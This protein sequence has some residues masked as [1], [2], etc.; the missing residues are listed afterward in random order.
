VLSR[1]LVKRDGARSMG[2]EDIVEEPIEPRLANAAAYANL[3]KEIA[4]SVRS[5]GFQTNALHYSTISLYND[6][7]I[8]ED[9]LINSRLVRY[10]RQSQVSITS[11]FSDPAITMLSMLGRE[12]PGLPLQS[13][14]E[15]VR[16]DLEVGEAIAR[17]RSIRT[18]T[19]DGLRLD[20]LATILRS[21]AGMTGVAE[22]DLTSGGQSLLRFRAAPSGGGLYPIDLYVAAL[23]VAD[24]ERGLYLYNP[25]K[26]ALMQTRGSSAVEHLIECFAAPDELISIHR[27]SVVFL[28]VGQPWRSMRKYG[29]RGM[30]FLFLETGAMAENIN[31]ATVALGFGSLD[32]AS[33]YD[34]EVHE[35]MGLD[36]LYQTLLHAVIVGY[37]G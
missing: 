13:L 27:A 22:V 23:K 28:L 15:S 2:N 7:R 1:Y 17:R 31:L 29:T 24:L 14:P 8:A 19:G 16:L 10:D 33:F 4:P 6:E 32:C 12:D 20:Y 34:D 3:S 25:T 9:F 26:D 5:T 21:A 11:Y 30:R 18:Y 36:G 37:P 35:A